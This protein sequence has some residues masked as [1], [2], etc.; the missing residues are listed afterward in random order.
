MGRGHGIVIL[1]KTAFEIDGL[2]C[3]RLVSIHDLESVDSY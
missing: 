2:Y 3:S 1:A